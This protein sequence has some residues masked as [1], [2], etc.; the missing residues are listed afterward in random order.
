MRVLHPLAHCCWCGGQFYRARYGGIRV[1]LC[2]SKD[3]T[4]RQLA[5][6]LLVEV[7]E[8][9]QKREKALYVPLPKQVEFQEAVKRSKR[10]LFGG[11]AGGSKSH[12]LRWFLYEQCLTIPRFKAL[13]MRRNM[14]ELERTHINEA[15]FEVRDFQGVLN[16]SKHTVRFPNDSELTFGHLDDPKDVSKHLSTEY[17]IIAFDELVTFPEQEALLIMSRARTTKDYAPRVIAGTNPGGPEAY[18]V[19]RRWL[20]K[21][22]TPQEDPRYDPDQ[23]LYVPSTLEDNPY[24][25]AAYEDSLLSLPEELRRAYRMGDWDIFPGQFFTEWRR[26]RH[27]VDGR[28]KPEGRWYI[29]VDWGYMAPGVCLFICVTGEGQAIVWHEYVFRQTIASE[30]AANIKKIANELGIHQVTGP[31]DTEMW[32]PQ[33]DSGES[34]AETMDRFGVHLTPADKDRVNGWARLRHWLRDSP[35]GEP[36]LTVHED[37]RYL[38]RTLPSLIMHDKFPEDIADGLEDHAADALRY[39]AMA[40]PSP[41]TQWVKR[42][43]PIDSPAWLLKQE[44]SRSRVRLGG[45][46]S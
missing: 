22:L 29:A 43:P 23:Y 6:A 33:T 15:E 4:D 11:A 2:E 37:C 27:V 45:Q 26:S 40:R 20:D 42:E 1:W 13:L 9:G 21:N 46:I 16:K 10:V 30:V 8:K 28:D 44:K 3:C 12:A 36:W 5:K 24:L 35:N 14:T 25:D 41:E 19:K 18:W 31:G 38:A 34:I 32:R 17:E 39:F 7:Q